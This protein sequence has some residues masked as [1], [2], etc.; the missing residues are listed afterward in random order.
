MAAAHSGLKT[1]LIGA[2]IRRPSLHRIF[3]L[4]K[5]PGLIEAVT[6]RVPWRDTVRGTVDYLRDTA[7]TALLMKRKE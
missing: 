3:G 5:E 1:M 7:N 4:P 6:G 2:D